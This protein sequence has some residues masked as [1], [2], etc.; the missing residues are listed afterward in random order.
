MD[1]ISRDDVEKMGQSLGEDEVM[2]RVIALPH[3][4]DDTRAQVIRVDPDTVVTYTRAIKAAAQQTGL[5]VMVKTL[6]DG[7]AIALETDEERARHIRLNTL[8]Q[9]PSP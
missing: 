8:T 2:P 7:M 4:L 3:G 9:P 5:P 1:E 6:S